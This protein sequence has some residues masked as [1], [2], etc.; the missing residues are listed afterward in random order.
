MRCC[1]SSSAVADESGQSTV[2]AEVASVETPDVPAIPPSSR[3]RRRVP[4]VIQMEQTECGAACLAMVLG[5]FGQF[6]T[7]AE[8]REECLVSRDGTSALQLAKVARQRGLSAHGFHHDLDGLGAVPTPAILFWSFNHFVVLEGWDRKGAWINDPARGPRRASWDEM[9]R[10]FTGVGVAF[11]RTDA[12]QRSGR[13]PSTLRRAPRLLSG[14]GRSLIFAAVLGVLAALPGI[15]AA[16]FLSFFINA[17][18]VPGDLK[19]ALPFVVALLVTLILQ[20]GFGWLTM[21]T[22]LGTTSSFATSLAARVTWRMLRLPMRYFTQRAPGEV[23]WR[24]NLP[25]DIG[26]ALAGPLPLAVVSLVSLVLYGAAMVVISPWAAVVGIVVACANALVMRS[27][28]RVQRDGLGV[29]FQHLGKLSGEVSSGL[30]RI[31]YVKATGA[32]DELFSQFTGTQAFVVNARQRLRGLT[33]YL[34]T[35][36]GLLSILGSAAVMGIAGVQV[37]N[38][39]LAVGGLVALQ[40][41]LVGFLSPFSNLVQLGGTLSEVGASLAKVDDVME[42]AA[43]IDGVRVATTAESDQPSGKLIGR[44]EF[45][46]VVFGYN[47]AA[48]PLLRGLSFCVEPGHRIAFVGTSGA[49]KSTVSRLLT[50]LE[51]PWSGEILLDGVSRDAW[52]SA[53]VTSSLALV[54]QSIVLFPG[55]I[56]DNLTLWDSRIPS[57]RVVAA[58]RDAAIDDMVSARPG[59]YGAMVA[60]NARNVSGGQAQR[61]EIARALAQDPTILVL[62]EATSALDAATEV[63][64][65]EAIRRRGCT[66]VVIAHRMSTIRD[67]DLILVLD[68]GVVVQSGTHEELIEDD[69]LYRTLVTN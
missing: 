67:A 43:S 6:V 24:M 64:I 42:G 1:P 8:M 40:V 52:P 44:I 34:A 39:T 27:I 68:K 9:D 21:S 66:T 11:E 38:G 12:F 56:Q 7:L 48:E 47:P 32:E 53:V 13:P 35:V 25:S 15:A 36:P 16:G 30:S 28:T 4:T 45:R 10:C 59:G 17:I 61:I 18:L 50:G 58:T 41:L 55:T 69:G 37:I 51:R 2:A 60:E 3:R 19:F 31:E 5:S 22:V 57:D 65:D 62:D 29:F 54:D 20:V 23:V 49:G 33:Q 46:D 26:K 63:Q 14:Y